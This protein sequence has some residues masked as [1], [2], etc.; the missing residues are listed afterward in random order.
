MLSKIIKNYFALLDGVAPSGDLHD[1]VLHEVERVLITQ[2]L[3]Y[4]NNNQLKASEILGI[5]RNTFRKKLQQF[6][7][8]ERNT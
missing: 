1:K 7:D 2:T 4:T 3:E 8:H 5:N 6:I